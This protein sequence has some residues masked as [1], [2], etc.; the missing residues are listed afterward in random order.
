MN[1]YRLLYEFLRISYNSLSYIGISNDKFNVWSEKQHILNFKI[2]NLVFNYIASSQ[3]VEKKLTYYSSILLDL[4]IRLVYKHYGHRVKIYKLTINIPFASEA[5]F[6]FLSILYLFIDQLLSLLRS[7]VRLKND[8]FIFENNC[9]SKKNS[10]IVFGFHKNAFTFDDSIKTGAACTSFGEYLHSLFNKHEVISINE[11]QPSTDEYIGFY[12]RHIRIDS[13]ISRKIAQK[14]TNYFNFIKRFICLI[15]YLANNNSIYSFNNFLLNMVYLDKRILT[16]EFENI[17]KNI[18]LEKHKIKEIVFL[19]HSDTGLLRYKVDFQAKITVF[20]YSENVFLKPSN[21]LFLI[22]GLH[23]ESNL[24]NIL[25][26]APLSA[27]NLRG[28]SM[29]FTDVFSKID[30]I[31]LSIDNV[32]NTNLFIK[33][34]SSNSM[35]IPSNLGCKYVMHP[36]YKRSEKYIAIFDVPPFKREKQ[37]SSF[38]CGNL[39][40]DYEIIFNFLKSCVAT[41]INS[42]NSVIL[43]PKYSLYLYDSRYKLLYDQLKEEYKD[44]ILIVDDNTSIVSVFQ[45]T[46]KVISMPYT[47]TKIIAESLNIPSVYYVPEEYRVS[48]SNSRNKT[49]MLIGEDELKNFVRS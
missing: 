46:H 40:R 10:I 37:F 8:Y 24:K 12:G 48:F 27:F 7:I 15:K 41:S 6:I 1:F 21:H 9:K 33:G 22:E 4:I 36:S 16:Y 47:S 14:K 44:N 18:D 49:D 34:I 29:G 38:I 30:K 43:K 11:Y 31:I 19:P 45:F 39:T 23:D 20:N 5:I 42:G 17:L 35:Q 26:E 2:N 25:M 3:P 13:E 28:R 32:F